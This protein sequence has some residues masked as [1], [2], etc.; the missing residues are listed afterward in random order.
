MALRNYMVGLLP[1][2][3]ASCLV[4]PDYVRPKIV[5]NASWSEAQDARLG[6]D[7]VDVVWWRSFNDPIL[8]QLIEAAYH[9]NLSL[10]IAGLRIYE[11]RAQLG[12]AIGR[13]WPSNVDPIATGTA[14]GLSE[15]GPNQAIAD[16]RFGQYQ[17][18][19]D[20]VWELDIW[21]KYRHGIRAAD[22]EWMATVAD[23]DDALVSLSAE[24]ARTYVL[25]RMFE[26]LI[27][28]ARGNVAIQ[29]EGLQIAEAR[30][31]N[32]A[33]SELDVTQARN[34]LETT[35]ATI[36]D[37]QMGQTQAEN[38]LSTLLGQPT[39]HVR[40]VLG[41]P[42]DI[43]LP[44]VKVAVSVP[45]EMMRR[46]PDIRAAE[47]RAIAQCNRVGVAK[48]ELYPSFVLFGSVGT[49][50]SSNG[51]MPSNNSTLS[52]LFGP[53]SLVYTAGGS[54][55][56]PILQ[57]KRIRNNV[58]VEDAR[59][60][61]TLVGYV[62]TVLR[63]AQ[64]VEDGMTGYLRQQEAATFEQN[65]VAAAETGVKIAL[66][67][68]REGAVDYTRVLDTQRSL[69]DSQQRLANTRAASITNLIALYKALGGGWES[70]QGD[71]VINDHNRIE[72]E[73]R[74]SWGG[75]L[76]TPHE[77]TTFKT[78]SAPSRR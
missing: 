64:E 33:T 77:S 23:Y 55:F 27:A 69:L 18:G 7:P 75:Y 42:A 17:V 58:R 76:E 60:Q 21:G 22:A 66:I 11:A 28:Q 59:F 34:L 25:I 53:G 48:S 68:Y 70:R 50:T 45:A 65:A 4:G 40:A 52:N 2:L 56:W 38:A 14:V 20:A 6:T 12:V 3:A 73:S 62:D 43:P 29:E 15:H 5:L 74:T 9:Q 32:G 41:N 49:Q 47:L 35:R 30:F 1:L 39:G 46:R 19:F 16:K 26:V 72:M 51:G 8:D 10:Q 13:W 44:P 36:P 37:L 24:V 67:Q 71:P 61:Q 57:Y 78:E 31:K 63:A 54:L